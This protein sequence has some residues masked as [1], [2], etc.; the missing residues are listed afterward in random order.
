MKVFFCIEDEISR[1]VAERLIFECCPA[2]TVTQELGKTYGGNGYIRSNLT[3]FRELS[4]TYPVLI[5]TDLDKESCAPSFR[6]KLLSQA[7]ITEPIPENMLLCIAQ[8][9]IE[10]WILADTIGVA[11]F[12]EISAARIVDRVETAI[13]DSKEYLL[14]L[15]LGSRNRVVKSDLLPARKSTASVG[16]NYNYRLSQFV[17]NE[18]NPK[19]GAKNSLSLDRALRKLSNLNP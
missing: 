1:A 5:I 7:S 2:G 6:R 16:L 11:R 19:E 12:L 15:A 4:K 10:S 13:V 14:S 9:E 8:T 17:R 3:K 18:W